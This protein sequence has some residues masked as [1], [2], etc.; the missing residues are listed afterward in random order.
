MPTASTD[1]GLAAFLHD[2]DALVAAVCGAELPALLPALAHLTGDMSL[3]DDALRPP[4]R[5]LP[6]RVEPQ[7][8]MSP[9]TQRRARHRALRAL[10]AFRDGGMAPARQPDEAM[11]RRL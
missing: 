1:A 2:E 7:G 4:L 8:G 5:L 3:V 10:R 9:A 11:L 6:D